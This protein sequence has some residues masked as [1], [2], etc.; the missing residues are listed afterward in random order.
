MVL[1]DLLPQQG[2]DYSMALGPFV[3][4]SKKLGGIPLFVLVGA[5]LALVLGIGFRSQLFGT[6]NSPNETDRVPTSQTDQSPASASTDVSEQPP[7]NSSSSNQIP[8]KSKT[9][10]EIV[11]L[12][13]HIRSYVGYEL[14]ISVG[15]DLN[16][17]GTCKVTLT[18][19]GSSP[20]VYEQ[21][22]QPDLAK[23][24]GY[25]TW[26]SFIKLAAMREV[27]YW[28]YLIN[29]GQW[30]VNARIFN[31]ISEGSDTKTLEI[32]SLN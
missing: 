7:S 11:G 18:R 25:A 14:D 16:T 24:N 9:K 1:T 13:A 10:V 30:T 4:S 22:T 26:C 17:S 2:Y 32:Q 19:T 31:S 8:S 6:K 28:H 3:W 15:S 27:T 21:V 29:P 20:I 5:V 23:P 12:S